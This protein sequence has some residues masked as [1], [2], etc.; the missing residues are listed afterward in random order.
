MLNSIGNFSLIFPIFLPFSF[1]FIVAL[2]DIISNIISYKFYFNEAGSP[3]CG[4]ALWSFLIPRNGCTLQHFGGR[5][6]Y[7]KDSRFWLVA[8]AVPLRGARHSG[9]VRHYRSALPLPLGCPWM[10]RILFP[11]SIHKQ[12]SLPIHDSLLFHTLLVYHFRFHNVFAIFSNVF[13]T[14]LHIWCLRNPFCWN[15]LTRPNALIVVWCVVLWRSLFRSYNIWGN[16]LYRCATI[17]V[18]SL[19]HLLF[20]RYPPVKW[21]PKSASGFT[22]PLAVATSNLQ[23]VAVR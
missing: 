6:E 13:F 17:S 12:G 8:A 15:E 2:H 10:L 16:S 18:N 5:T 14:F 11:V 23:K 22:G 9:G 19:T 4:K 20:I 21:I 3:E 7:S 1:I